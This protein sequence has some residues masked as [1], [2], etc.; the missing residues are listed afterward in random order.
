MAPMAINVGG[1]SFRLSPSFLLQE[2]RPRLLEV[3]RQL[4]SS[5]PR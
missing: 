4:E 2:V 1:P 3:V 5:F